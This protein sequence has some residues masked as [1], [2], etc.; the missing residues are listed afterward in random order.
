M[1][2]DKLAV[3][4]FCLLSGGVIA[5]DFYIDRFEVM[6]DGA[7][8]FIDDFTDGQ[9]PP[10]SEGTFPGSLP[11]TYSTRPAELLGPEQDGKLLMNPLLGEAIDSDSS[12]GSLLIQRARLLT[13]TSDDPANNE[14]G[15]KS[16]LDFAVIG[17]FDLVRPTTIDARYG[18]RLTDLGADV[19]DDLVQVRVELWPGSEW[20][21]RFFES[22]EDETSFVE[23]DRV[24]LDGIADIQEYEQIV[25]S[26]IKADA[27]STTITASFTLIDTDGPLAPLTQAL[28]GA[29]S[30]F[31]GETWTRAAFFASV[32]EPRP[33]FN[34]IP[35]VLQPL[36]LDD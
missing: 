28:T 19:P 31:N 15:L 9:V 29:A 1:K 35:P 7:A 24:D 2:F 5:D 6:R 20:L 30:A 12:G 33:P 3:L 17:T 36:L 14:L 27:A 21:V 25:L 18:V 11:T 34:R 16:G 23:F 22:G 4:S 26:L 13:D 8:W 10:S 32:Q